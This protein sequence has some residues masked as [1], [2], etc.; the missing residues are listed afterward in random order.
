MSFESGLNPLTGRSDPAMIRRI[1][2]DGIKVE[3]RETKRLVNDALYGSDKRGRMRRY[4]LLAMLLGALVFPGLASAMTS[5]TLERVVGSIPRISV[6]ILCMIVAF[7]VAGVWVN[8]YMRLHRR[9]FR[10]AMRRRGFDLCIGCGYWLKGLSDDI[11]RCSECGRPREG[12][13][14]VADR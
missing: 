9:R 2:I 4:S 3:G 1:I 7:V 12:A 14:T 13:E 6:M 11:K 8:V 5:V 10:E